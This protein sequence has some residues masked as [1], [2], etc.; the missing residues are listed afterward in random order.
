MAK[1]SN[2]IA[3]MQQNPCDVRFVDLKK[4]CTH[5]FGEARQNKTS[6]LVYK[7]PWVGDPRINIQEGKN[8]KAKTYQVR[9]VLSAIEKLEEMNE[10]DED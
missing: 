6:H 2:I 1:I 10:S 3:V 7:T 8:G 4:V 5:Y 9:Q